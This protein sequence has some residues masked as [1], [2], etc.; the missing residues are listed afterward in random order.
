MKSRLKSKGYQ[1]AFLNGRFMEYYSLIHPDYK[2]KL[3]LCASSKTNYERYYA[4]PAILRRDANTLLIVYKNGLEH[5]NDAKD[6]LVK[7]DQLMLDIPTQC[8]INRSTVYAKPDM[9]PQMGEYVQMPNGDICVYIDMQNSTYWGKRTGM[10]YLRST[11]GG[12]TYSNS[13]KFG[14][15]D[16]VEYG[17]PLDSCYKNG[18]VYLLVM[19]F[20]Y[21]QGS[22]NRRQ[23]HLIS[24]GDN[25]QTWRFEAN[26]TKKLGL[27]FNESSI[28]A[29]ENGFALFTRG[30]APRYRTNHGT[31]SEAEN[32][33][34]VFDDEFNLLRVRDYRH[35]RC[36]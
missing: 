27:E 17:Y 29:L 25:G 5:G 18:R 36:S 7:L 34:A 15:I 6:G 23:V 4:F 26:F 1:P 21:L 28:V 24:T 32:V 35:T 30:E 10:E 31:D 14:V 2:E 33:L 3:T 13:T 11:D 8:V 20:E 19:T 9:I 22:E 16:G 12:M